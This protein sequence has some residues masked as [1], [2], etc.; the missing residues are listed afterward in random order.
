MRN[1]RK[2]MD[3]LTQRNKEGGIT[4]RDLSASLQKL[5]EY[6]DRLESA[7]R[8]MPLPDIDRILKGG[9]WREE[10]IAHI[11]NCYDGGFPHWETD[12]NRAID[13]VLAFVVSDTR[14][15]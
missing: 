4:V 12:L 9:D 6:E 7:T 15:Y 10:M 14:Y 1:P 5:A 3:R 13:A 11:N 8:I 2:N